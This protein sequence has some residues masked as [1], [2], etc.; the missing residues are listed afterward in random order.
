M[1]VVQ[2]EYAADEDDEDADEYGDDQDYDDDQEEEEEEEEDE[3]DNGEPDDEEQWDR[4]WS[5]D[6]RNSRGVNT[7]VAS[8][9]TA[10]SDKVCLRIIPASRCSALLVC[11]FLLC[12]IRGP[13]L[14]AAGAPVSVAAKDRDSQGQHRCDPSV[15]TPKYPALYPL[16]PRSA[17]QS[18]ALA[19]RGGAYE[20]VVG[21]GLRCCHGPAGSNQPAKHSAAAAAAA[22]AV[23]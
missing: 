17:R 1:M 5:G 14:F 4:G 23:F 10:A 6:A 2:V 20:V 7:S 19:G 8:D 18:S 21:A 9:D 3:D 11:G 13:Q 16:T 22:A 15:V 12:F